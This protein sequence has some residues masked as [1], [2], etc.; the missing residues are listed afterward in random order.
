MADSR[1]NNPNID[2]A[3]NDTLAGTLRSVFAQ[4]MRNVDGTLPARVLRY[5][6]DTNRVQVE[7]LIAMITTSGQQVSR[8]QIANI[9]VINLGGGGFL[10]NFP[11]KVGDLGFIM[12][13]DRDIS[14]F[15]QSFSEAPP[16]T[17]R[18]KSFSDSIFIPS[19]LTDYT[20]DG[21]DADNMVIQ[22]LDGTVKISLGPDSVNIES[23]TPGITHNNTITLKVTNDSPG[24]SP[25]IILDKTGITLDSPEVKVTGLLRATGGLAVTGIATTIYASYFGGPIYV[26]GNGDSSVA[27]TPGVPG[28]PIPPPPPP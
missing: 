11:L 10:I 22:N 24:Y 27:F 17:N 28:A 5:D 21:A 25:S 15:L 7:V 13:N 16:N 12:A 6:R 4:L 19:V 18:V 2:P 20:I 8:A 9:P 14:L 26:L 3:N 23:N 1:G